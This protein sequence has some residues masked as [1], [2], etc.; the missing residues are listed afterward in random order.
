MTTKYFVIIIVSLVFIKSAYAQN[1]QFSEIVVDTTLNLLVCG[2]GP[3][4]IIHYV[5]TRCDSEGR[6]ANA[7]IELLSKKSN[8]KLQGW[9]D[10]ISD[11]YPFVS[12]SQIP[13]FIDFNFDGYQDIC[14]KSFYSGMH[15]VEQLVS[16]WQFNPN[17]NTFKKAAQFDKMEGSISIG[18]NQTIEEYKSMGCGEMCWIKNIYKYVGTTFVFVKQVESSWDEKARDYIE[19]ERTD[20]R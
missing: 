4:F 16:F 15:P 11:E 8:V 1:N 7:K 6:C 10:T 19:V 14:F 2:K 9:A 20:K 12:Y 3:E 5:V 18:D 17:T 13:I